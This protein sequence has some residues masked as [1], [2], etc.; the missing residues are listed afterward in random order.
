MAGLLAERQERGLIDAINSGYGQ[1]N[2]Q[3]F[4][5]IGA[6]GVKI[7]NVT[8][9]EKFEG[10]SS[11]G[12]EPYTDV[13]ISTTTKKINVSNKG[14]SAPSIAGGGLAGLELAVPGLTKKFLEAALK[15]YKKKGFKAGMSALPDMYG[16][17]SD[18]LKETIVVGNEKMGGP[19]HYM[20]IGPM[21]VKY[22]FL[23]GT[24]RVNGNFYEAKKYAKENDLYLRLRKRRE[25]QPFEPTK[26]DSKGL[27]LIL[28]RSPSR[29]DSGRRIVT[30]KKPPKNALTVEF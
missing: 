30:A 26:K 22:T 3:P 12:T 13:I 1:N 25:D 16:K 7:A 8:F 4:T 5:L 20:Y 11:A 17:V 24:L 28:G 27:P 19:I 23:N 9:A 21:D 2:G 10:R 6:N 18:S 15:E 14:E 29:G